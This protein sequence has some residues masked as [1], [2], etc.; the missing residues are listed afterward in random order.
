MGRRRR[1]DDFEGLVGPIAVILFL[2]GAVIIAFLR[3]LLLAVLIG[4]GLAS[5]SGPSLRQMGASLRRENTR[6]PW[7]PSVGSDDT[8]KEPRPRKLTF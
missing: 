8:S 2:F 6:S 4:G 7:C 5:R 3:A 1:G